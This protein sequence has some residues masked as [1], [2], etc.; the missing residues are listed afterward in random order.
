MK[1]LLLS[2]AV[3]VIGFTQISA[4]D[5]S[6]GAKAGANFSTV[7]GDVDDTTMRVGLHVGAVAEYMLNDK[8]ALQAELLYSMQGTKNEYQETELVDSFLETYKDEATVKLDYINIPVMFKYYVTEGLSVEAGPQVGFLISAKLD[9]ESTYTYNDEGTI[10]TESSK[11]SD[12]DVK[13]TFKTLDFG[14]NF[15]LGYKLDNG[16]NFGARYNLGLAN[17][18][19]NSDNFPGD[20]DLDTKNSV[21]QVSVGFMF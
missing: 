7:T 3:A 8:M 10:V 11:L 9:L 1:K 19:D 16:L 13:D 21:I 12:F 2:A 4:Q 20:P 6:F 14:L 15:G 17:T 18:S 5:F